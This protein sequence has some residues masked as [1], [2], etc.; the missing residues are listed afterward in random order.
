MFIIWVREIEY[1]LLAIN[2]TGSVRSK[3]HLWFSSASF[4]AQRHPG[5]CI[6]PNFPSC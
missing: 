4:N 2:E 5:A 6:T 3:M 1:L